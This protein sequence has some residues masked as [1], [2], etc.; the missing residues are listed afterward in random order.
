MTGSVYTQTHTCIHTYADIYI[1]I[2]IHIRIKI[3]IYI[4][5]H[6]HTHI[7]IYIYIYIYIL[8]HIHKT[9]HVNVHIDIYIQICA[10]KYVWLNNKDTFCQY[11]FMRS[12]SSFLT[13]PL[14]LG[15][16]WLTNLPKLFGEL[17]EPSCVFI[18]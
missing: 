16:N 5:I 6:T 13:S 7:Y 3:Y 11:D 12:L 18:I 1:H 2:Y 4:H 17:S 10:Y 9:I 8:R 15:W 14:I